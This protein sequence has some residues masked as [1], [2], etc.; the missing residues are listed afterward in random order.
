MLF[1]RNQVTCEVP[2]FSSNGEPMSFARNQS[3]LS[4]DDVSN[5]QG[6]FVAAVKNCFCGPSSRFPDDFERLC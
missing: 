1:F 2:N 4:S 5:L 3:L 6:F